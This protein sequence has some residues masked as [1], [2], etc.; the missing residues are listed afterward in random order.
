MKYAFIFPQKDSF[1]RLATKID[2]SAVEA[3]LPQEAQRKTLR[4][5]DTRYFAVYGTISWI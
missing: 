4:G 3:N 1:A 2:Q 5:T